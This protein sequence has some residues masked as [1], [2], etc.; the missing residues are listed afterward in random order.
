VSWFDTEQAAYQE[1]RRPSRMATQARAADDG[2]IRPLGAECHACLDPSGPQRTIS[3]VPGQPQPRPMRRLTARRSLSAAQPVLR[4]LEVVEDRAARVPL[5]SQARSQSTPGTTTSATHC[6]R[7]QTGT[8]G[9]RAPKPDRACRRRMRSFAHA[10]LPRLLWRH[11]PRAPVAT[12]ARSLRPVEPCGSSRRRCSRRTSNA[13]NVE[14]VERLA[15]PGRSSGG[16]RLAA[17]R[18]GASPGRG[19]GVA[20]EGRLAPAAGLAPAR[21]RRPTSQ[22]TLVP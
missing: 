1:F 12:S 6:R 4:L 21:A 9:M 3:H 14:V 10:H 22:S 17:E 2:S 18:G 19:C 5:S 7:R 15:P 11:L 8:R 16:A 13:R 20:A